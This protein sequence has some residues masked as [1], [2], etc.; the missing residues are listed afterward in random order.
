MKFHHLIFIG[1]LIVF[2]DIN[3]GTVDILNDII[4]YIVIANAFFK[5]LHP[6]AK[7]GGVTAILL[8]AFAVYE[9]FTN[10]GNTFY[11]LGTFNLGHELILI[12]PGVLMILNTAC[13]LSVSKTLVV[14]NDV[15]FPRIYMSA[16]ILYEIYLSFIYFMDEQTATGTV[17]VAAIVIFVLHIWFIVFIWQRKKLESQEK[18]DIPTPE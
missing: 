18:I 1:L 14:T 11:E 13:I 15:L 4:G 6:H 10:T 9:I 16:L 2:I 7:L 8:A 12:V 3:I 17:L 5:T